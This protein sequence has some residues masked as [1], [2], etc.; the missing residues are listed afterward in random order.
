[1]CLDYHYP[2]PL[3]TL[4]GEKMVPRGQHNFRKGSQLS[5]SL[6]QPTHSSSSIIKTTSGSGGKEIVFSLSEYT[7]KLH[8]QHPVGRPSPTFFSTR[9]GNRQ[10]GT[11]RISLWTIKKARLEMGDNNLGELWTR[12][13]PLGVVALSPQLSRFCRFCAIS[14]THNTCLARDNREPQAMFI[15]TTGSNASLKL[16]SAL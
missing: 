2:S 15:C 12:F 11:L 10:N 8:V 6:S 7:S 4:C 5:S 9:L 13:S 16:V 14:K 1:M 3:I